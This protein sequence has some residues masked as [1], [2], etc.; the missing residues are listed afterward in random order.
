MESERVT[1]RLPRPLHAA[2]VR[3]A[4][5]DLGPWIRGLIEAATGVPAGDMRPGILRRTASKRK[6]DARTAAG[7]R[8][9][10]CRKRRNP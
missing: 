10:L 4:A 5:G 8:H 6:A 9:G 3:K 7:V 1:V 2:A